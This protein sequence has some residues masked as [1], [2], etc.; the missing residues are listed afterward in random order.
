[1]TE[2]INCGSQQIK[3]KKKK[4]FLEEIGLNLCIFKKNRVLLSV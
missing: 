3:L 4:E 1:M 2:G